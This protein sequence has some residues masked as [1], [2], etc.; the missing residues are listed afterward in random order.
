MY[1]IGV[2]DRKMTPLYFYQLFKASS[3]KY[4]VMENIT[5]KLLWLSPR[6]KGKDSGYKTNTD[7]FAAFDIRNIKRITGRIILNSVNHAD[8]HS[9]NWINVY[10]LQASKRSRTLR[11]FKRKEE[12]RKREL[13]EEVAAERLFLMERPRK[14]NSATTVALALPWS[15]KALKY[16]GA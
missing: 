9:G 8:A 10:K 12:K 2:T 13:S 6:K 3:L 14:K 16:S 5:T 4:C 1:F 15:T 7:L 11:I